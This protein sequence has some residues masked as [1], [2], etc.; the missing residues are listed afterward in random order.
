MIVKRCFQPSWFVKW[1]WLHYNEAQ[2][3]VRCL[4]CMKASLEHKLQWAS[5]S[6]AAFITAGF[7]NWKDASAKF[8]KHQ[9]SSCH[10]EAVLKTVTLPATTRDVGETLSAQ[11]QQEK[12]ERRQ[13]LLKILSN[14]KFLA[15]QGLPLRGHGDE[16]D[17]NFHQLLKLRSEDDPRVKTWLSKKTDKYT[18][19]DVQN[20]MLKVMAMH[21][22]RDVAASIQ[23]AP[24]CT[25]MVDETTDISNKEQVVLC[26][27]W[28]D[29]TLEAHEEF[30]GMYQ[31][32]STQA[33]VLLHVIH[34][35]LTRLN[36]CV[37]KLRGQCYDGAATMSGT[38]AGVATLLLEEEPRAVFTHCYGHS[39]NLACSDTVRQC[40][41]MR[42]ALDTVY[43]VI[44]LVKKSPRRDATLQRL[45]QELTIQSPGIRVICP[46]RWTV[47]AQSLHS[48][49]DNY[50]ALQVLWEESL[51]FV[52]EAEMRSRI[53]GV[54]SRM[55]SF[56]FLFGVLLGELL[57]RHS[58]NLSKALQSSHMSAAEGQKVA[59]MTVKTLESLRTEENFKLFWAKAVK[60]GSDIGVDEPVLP[61]RRKAP[62][63]YRIGSS[64]GEFPENAEVMYRQIF[65]EVLDLIVTSIKGRFDQ[66][67]YRVY[68]KLED[69][70]VK[71]AR[72][73]DY[74]EELE[75]VTA[76]YRE[77]IDSDRL[78]MQLDVLSSNFP[79]DSSLHDLQSILK[80]LKEL[81]HPQR[82]LMSEVCTLASLILVMPASNA[83]SER[84]FS[85]L[86]RLK[87]YL[88]STMTQERLNSILMLHVHNDLTDNL[89]LTEIGNEFVTG[90][91]HRLT[92][93]GKFLER[94]L[95]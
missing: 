28:V 26:F 31:V 43:E 56:D 1:P 76:F 53:M 85:S 16:G 66:S 32:E 9:S 39:L 19:A 65:Y 64:E 82:T 41:F 72:K 38:R 70:L 69:L 15:R 45:K 79:E 95:I 89:N 80:Y 42:N 51:E 47:H 92:L 49:L 54:L 5:N 91:E 52:K 83:V 88:R 50:E 62:K 57:F 44:K 60:M 40:K 37:A 24:F 48:I 74:S 3:S 23:S 55:T 14:V 67:G 11:H 73:E 35:V 78:K 36:V 20:E 94:D 4:T 93:F 7:S 12:M 27:R 77:D 58:D 8:A 71:A 61:R 17:S 87:S 86:R 46:T 30:V 63:R 75:F 2:D 59:A 34:D 21:V 6:E 13:C 81:S 90:S 68:C 84:S 33:S 29:N 25:L 18:S 22:L 10:K